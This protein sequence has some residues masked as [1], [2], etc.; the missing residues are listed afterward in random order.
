MV[1]W[2]LV[3]PKWANRVK[4][5]PDKTSQ[6]VTCWYKV[7]CCLPVVWSVLSLWSQLQEVGSTKPALTIQGISWYSPASGVSYFKEKSYFISCHMGRRGWITPFFLLKLCL[8]WATE[9][10]VTS[11][12]LTNKR[13]VVLWAFRCFY[14]L[15]DVNYRWVILLPCWVFSLESWSM[16][17]T[18]TW[19]YY[20]VSQFVISKTF[21]SALS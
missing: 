6:F 13:A 11:L 19:K 8:Q 21:S 9:G 5:A 14:M 10:S 12:S 20:F 15:D 4:R 1:S 7:C 16:F 2:C 3:T 18:Y 17:S